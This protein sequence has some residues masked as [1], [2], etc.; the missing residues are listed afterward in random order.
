MLS[1]T[2]FLDKTLLTVAHVVEQS[3]F[4]EAY[5]RKG[6]L[7]QAH[8]IRVKLFSF[9]F[10]IVMI[11]LFHTP[12]TIWVLYGFRLALALLSRVSLGVFV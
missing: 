1:R 4:S 6:G 9:L 12:Q 5:A 7:L 8:D 10:L 11:S 2:K 3:L